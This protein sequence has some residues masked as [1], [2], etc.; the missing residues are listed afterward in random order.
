MEIKICKISLDETVTFAAE[1]LKKYLYLIDENVSVS[2]FTYEKYS[3]KHTD[4]IWI[5][6]DPALAPKVEDARYDDAFT[7]NI[8][9]NAGIIAGTNPVSTLIAVYSLIKALGV[10]FIR[11]GRDGE[12]IEKKTLSPI[13]LSLSESASYRFR[14][15]NLDCVDSVETL[16]GFIDWL[17]KEGMNHYFFEYMKPHAKLLRYYK[18]LEE[19]DAIAAF[20]TV[21]EEAKKRG[22][23][24]HGVGHGWHLLALG[25]TETE[26]AGNTTIDSLT[27]E[28]IDCLALRDGK[29]SIYIDHNLFGTQ[30]CYSKK[31]LRDKM[32]EEIVAYLKNNPEVDYLHFWLADGLNNHCE[33]ED[34]KKHR[35]SDWYIMMLNDLDKRLT[36]E[37]ITSRIVCLIYVDLLWEPVEFRLENPDRFILMFAPITRTY[38]TSYTRLDDPTAKKTPYERNKL[39]WPRSA[40]EN[41]LYLKDWREHQLKGDSFIFD[42]HLMW[43]QY[44]EPGYRNLSRVIYEDMKNL[45]NLGLGGSVSCEVFTCQFPHDFPHK[46]MA[47]TLWNKNVDY[48][49][50]EKKYFEESYG[51]DYEKVFEYFDGVSAAFKIIYDYYKDTEGTKDAQRALYEKAVAL[52][53]KIRP[54][55]EENKKKSHPRAVRLSWEMLSLHTEYIIPFAKAY[56]EKYQ[57]NADTAK[58]AL[59]EFD[60]VCDRVKEKFGNYFSLYFSKFSVGYYCDEI[61]DHGPNVVLI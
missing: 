18:G 3:E 43:N 40:A 39:I 55:I 29:R 53:E 30:L 5:T 31:H 13:T 25:F 46:I 57:G 41:A 56:C 23:K 20:K 49:A 4:C 7:I 14:G 17:P 28:Q 33:C 38:D 27:S 32:N 12:I 1:E 10:K 51:E 50:E 26:K 24:R 54:V 19:V 16:V 45:E 59:E 21:T 22:L 15:I 52:A 42:Y 44:K 34:C 48:D 2:I 47:R 6:A 35:P 61:T 9:E 8:S 36:E 37:N 60:A 58:K 11:P